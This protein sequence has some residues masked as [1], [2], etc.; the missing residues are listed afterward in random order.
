[1]RR[2]TLKRDL[3]GIQCAPRS[4]TEPL[5]NLTCQHVSRS[6][7][8]TLI[9]KGVI[10]L[11]FGPTP[12]DHRRGRLLNGSV[13]PYPFTPPPPPPSASGLLEATRASWRGGR[14]VTLRENPR[15]P[16][17]RLGGGGGCGC[18]CGWQR[19]L[20][21]PPTVLKW[22]GSSSCLA[23]LL[24]LLLLLLLRAEM[25]A[26]SCARFVRPSVHCSLPNA[27]N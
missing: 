24:L 11:K 5:R 1:M 27:V 18:G 8:P 23:H 14:A 3:R 20:F 7:S 25:V 26:P 17:C 21:S 12:N 13:C 4:D 9:S 15:I 22:H 10:L 6:P 19:Y 16:S 2:E